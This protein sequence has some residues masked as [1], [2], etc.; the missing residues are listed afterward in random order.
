MIAMIGCTTE[1]ATY[2][3]LVEKILTYYPL[4]VFK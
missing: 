4:N 1:W 2:T 3:P